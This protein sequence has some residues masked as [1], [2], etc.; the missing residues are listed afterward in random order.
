MNVDNGGTGMKARCY[1]KMQRNAAVN[2]APR[3]IRGLENADA[4]GRTDFIDA[5]EQIEHAEANVD[6]VHAGRREAALRAGVELQY[7]RQRFGI[8]K[9][10]G[11]AAA[12]D[13]V[14]RIGKRLAVDAAF[15]IDRNGG[16]V[17]MS[18]GTR[19]PLIWY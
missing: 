13:R 16:L 6:R 4:V 1:S 10:A 8:G 19:K 17:L 2:G 11:K 7:L 14:G 9:A 15:S 12:V 18:S 3:A 5:V